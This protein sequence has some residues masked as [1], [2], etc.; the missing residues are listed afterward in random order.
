M[1]MLSLSM[2]ISEPECI[3]ARDIDDWIEMG[4]DFFASGP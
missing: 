3:A 4:A 1:A 2:A